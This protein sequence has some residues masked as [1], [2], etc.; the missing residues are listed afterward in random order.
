MDYIDFNFLVLIT[1][2][3][4]YKRMSLFLK[5]ITAVLRGKRVCCLLLTFK[6]SKEN[7]YVVYIY[8]GIKE[9]W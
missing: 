1:V 6:S 9:M 5:T 3:G 4:L 8:R 7:K 2:Q